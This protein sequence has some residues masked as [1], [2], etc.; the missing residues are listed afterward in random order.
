VL[1]VSAWPGSLSRVV[2][3]RGQAEGSLAAL[4]VAA[5]ASAL[6]PA[7]RSGSFR[8]LVVAHVLLALVLLVSHLVIVG[9]AN[10]G[11]LK[12]RLVATS[13]RLADRLSSIDCRTGIEQRVL[14][15]HNV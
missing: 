14:G 3:H 11:P 9:A 13:P 12:Q 10:M 6:R 8:L 4:S 5:A 15:G 2:G 1:S 7:W